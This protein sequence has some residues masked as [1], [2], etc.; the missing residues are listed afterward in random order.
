MLAVGWALVACGDAGP[1]PEDERAAEVARELERLA[2]V[3][4][5]RTAPNSPLDVGSDQ[6]LLFD[7]YEVTWALWEGLAP[8]LG[9]EIDEVFVPDQPERRAPGEPLTAPLAWRDE[10]PV[11]GMTLAEAQAFAAARR[12]RLPTFEEWMWC[13]LGPRSRILPAGRYQR[14]LANT[15][16]LGLY[17]ATPVGAF[18]SG[19]TS[20]SG[21]Y[22][23]VGN[24][25]EWT[26]NPPDPASG[27][28]LANELSW[29]SGGGRNAP[30]CCVGGSFSSR[31]SSLYTRRG[32]VM[33]IGTT[34]GHRSSETGFRC[35][36]S[37]I[38][39]LGS[40]PAIELLPSDVE[41]RVRLVGAQWGRSALRTLE[42]LE[43]SGRGTPWVG[44]LLAG[45]RP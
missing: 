6:D 27:V 33:A 36:V 42:S 40:L 11:T 20:G 43:R 39:Y 13:A 21:V 23:L 14:G 19:K 32:E 4:R 22:D 25:W 1:G 38:E 28:V 26:A 31:V 2:F 17:R 9:L 24:V 12:M 30:A 34:P 8:G 7:R 10:I 44:A 29:P 16:D 18:E 35:A 15:A 3:E 45:A 5:G 41:E 37:A